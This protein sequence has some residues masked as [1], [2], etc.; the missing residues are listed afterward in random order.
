MELNMPYVEIDNVARISFLY[1]NSERISW[2]EGESDQVARR[3]RRRGSA[4]YPGAHA[5]PQQSRITDV[6]ADGVL[7]TGFWPLH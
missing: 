3:G 2:V 7:A 6:K 1:T 5:K 4:H